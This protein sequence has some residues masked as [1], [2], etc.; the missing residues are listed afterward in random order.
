[1]HVYMEKDTQVILA[2]NWIVPKKTIFTSKWA[3]KSNL[4]SILFLRNLPRIVLLTH[5]LKLFFVKELWEERNRNNYVFA[6][7]KIKQYRR[8][9]KLIFLNHTLCVKDGIVSSQ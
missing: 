3:F 7:Y 1:M 9:I 8:R 5:F 4:V 6:T 2:V